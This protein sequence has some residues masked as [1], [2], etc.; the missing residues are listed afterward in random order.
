[1]FAPDLLA[2]SVKIIPRPHNC[3][4]PALS[5]QKYQ[6][7]IVSQV[8]VYESVAMCYFLENRVGPVQKEWC[9]SLVSPSQ[10]SAAEILGDTTGSPGLLWS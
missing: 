6:N 10:V 4:R 3:P 8:S 2:K 9:F 7:V 1:M 5:K